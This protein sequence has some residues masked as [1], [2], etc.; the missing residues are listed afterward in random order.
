M[1][2]PLDGFL[3]GECLTLDTAA[4]RYSKLEY[5]KLA[6]VDQRI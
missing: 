1:D 5:S 4:Q 6:I 2:A 3:K